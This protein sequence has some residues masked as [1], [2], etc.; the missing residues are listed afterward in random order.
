M[1]PRPTINQE[2]R[3]ICLSV[4]FKTLVIQTNN[5]KSHLFLKAAGPIAL[6]CL[7]GCFSLFGQTPPKPDPQGMGGVVTGTPVKYASKRTVEIID[8]K[9]PVIF[10]D[11]TD[12]T[13]LSNFKHRSGTPAKEYIFEVPSGGVAIL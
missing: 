2:G 7:L 1:S 8:Q 3:E 4:L 9:A 6:L 12:K 11:A 5:M 13:A 10:E